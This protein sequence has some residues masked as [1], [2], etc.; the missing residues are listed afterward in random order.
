MD[1]PNVNLKLLDSLRSSPD[2]G[3]QKLLEIGT[4]GLHVLHRAFQTGH[5]A[6]SWSVNEFLRSA[7]GL[8]K[9]SLARRA[10]YTAATGSMLFPQNFC[11]VC[12]LANVDVATRALEFYQISRRTG[13]CRRYQPHFRAITHVSRSKRLVMIR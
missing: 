7:Y 3:D 9:D 10:D 8:F 11:Q 1:G 6:S 12:W 4:C 5:S 13:I 2:A